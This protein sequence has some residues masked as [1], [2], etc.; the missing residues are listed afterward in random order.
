MVSISSL[1][2]PGTTPIMHTI[3]SRKSSGA[4]EYINVGMKINGTRISSQVFGRTTTENENQSG[5]A[6]G[7][8]SGRDTNYLS[9]CTSSSW[10]NFKDDAT[11]R[12]SE[13]VPS[14][15]LSNSY[16][17]ATVTSYGLN[18]HGGGT[19]TLGVDHFHIYS[20]AVS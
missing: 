19:V 10:V 5:S 6:F 13:T 11:H 3:P 1:S 14:T 2:I 15:N 16:I 8:T 18:V 12:S 20:L 17:T 7:V 9:G 4:S